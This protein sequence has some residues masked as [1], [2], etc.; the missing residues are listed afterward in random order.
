MTDTATLG[1]LPEWDLTDLYPGP[2]STE[3]PL[4]SPIPA[5]NGILARS[6]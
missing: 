1:S 6:H 2:D 5:D 3:L 4:A